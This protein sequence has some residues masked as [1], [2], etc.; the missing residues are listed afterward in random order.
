MKKL[1]TITILSILFLSRANSQQG[2]WEQTAGTPDGSGI[3]GLAVANN[4]YLFATTGS[5]DFFNSDTGGV[6]RSTDGGSTWEKVFPAYIART[7]EIDSNG[8]IFASVWDWPNSNEGIYKSTDMGTTWIPVHILGN[9]DNVFSIEAYSGGV[10]YAGSRK[11]IIVSTDNGNTWNTNPSFP[12]GETWVLDV[13]TDISGYI[14]A[15][16][17]AGFYISS[18]GGINWE[19]AQGIEAGDTVTSLGVYQSTNLNNSHFA[20][21]PIIAGTTNGKIYKAPSGGVNFLKVFIFAL[22]STSSDFIFFNK[23]ILGAVRN[24]SVLENS[25]Q[26]G[27]TGGAIVS[28]DGGENWEFQNEGLPTNAIA[29][30]VAV[31]PSTLRA[32]SVFYLGLFDNQVG[33]ARIFKRTF[34]VTNIENTDNETVDNFNLEQNYPNPFNPSTKIRFDLPSS[35]YASLKVYDMLGREI[36]ELV[37][38]EL[39][40]GI[41]EFTWNAHSLSSGT[42]F[43]E[44]K[45]KEYS[46]RKKMMLLK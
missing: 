25:A 44:L 3:T 5:Y 17:Y 43:Y 16:S 6:H 7:I 41:Y 33:G 22:S 28:Q 10:L 26:Y 46:L 14:Y 20:E 37:N 18:N 21:T 24:I 29:S 8:V 15:A 23:F 12:T 35:G 11:G 30:F 34:T 40:A 19:I 42:Y 13:E 9:S 32:G 31:D 39:S 27:T 38:E 4:G 1:L 2:M 36:A 45:T